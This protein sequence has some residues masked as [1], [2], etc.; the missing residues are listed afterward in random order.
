MKVIGFILLG[1]IALTI[2]L[3]LGTII[4][5]FIQGILYLIGELLPYFIIACVIVALVAIF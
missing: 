3:N 1:L 5:Y 2:I 4:R